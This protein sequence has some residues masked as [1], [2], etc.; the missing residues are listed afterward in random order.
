MEDTQHVENKVGHSKV[1]RLFRI[2]VAVIW[3]LFNKAMDAMEGNWRIIKQESDLFLGTLFTILGVFGFHSGKYCDGNTA[4]YLSCTRPT[5]FY[6]YGWLEIALIVAGVFFILL[7][8][9]KRRTQ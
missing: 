4:D 3:Y 9:Q 1:K 2:S 5:T 8:F 6:Y 7:W